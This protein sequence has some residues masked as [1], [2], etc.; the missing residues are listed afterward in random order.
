MVIYDI[1][2]E[3]YFIHEVIVKFNINSGFSLIEMAA[4]VTISGILVASAA[5]TYNIYQKDRNVS[6]TYYRMDKFNN[7]MQD[8]FK[9]QGRYP[10]P[11]DPM[12][13][14][15]GTENCANTNTIPAI[16]AG[17]GIRIAGGRATNYDGVGADPVYIGAIPYK[18]LRLGMEDINPDDAALKSEKE[19]ALGDVITRKTAIDGWGRQFTYIVTA[20]LTSKASFNPNLGAIAVTTETTTPPAVN[21]VKPNGSAAWA[22]LSHGYNGA[23]AYT[24]EG[25]ILSRPC[26]GLEQSNCTD[27]GMSTA[28]PTTLG[29]P[30]ALDITIKSGLR[31]LHDGVNYFDDM[32]YFSSAKAL[33]FWTSSRNDPNA[34]DSLAS[35]DITNTNIGFVGIGTST[36]VQKLDVIGNIKSNEIHATQICNKDGTK[37]FDPSNFVGSAFYLCPAGQLMIGIAAGGVVQCTTISPVPT[38]A[39]A[40]TGACII[41]GEYALGIDSTGALICGVP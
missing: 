37:C 36:P 41:S 3:S 14:E 10:C 35:R 1:I 16:V 20:A 13:P 32:V 21:L 30:A 31:N 11:A 8:F 33:G 5:G 18:T 19:V 6:D 40:T 9:A 15:D 39:L 25:G 2:K 24:E 34:S 17:T 12:A 38:S 27:I 28:V 26:K 29:T 22:V 7:N 4:V 23:G